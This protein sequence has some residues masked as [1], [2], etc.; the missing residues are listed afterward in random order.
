MAAGGE[1]E[2]AGPSRPQ[3]ARMPARHFRRLIARVLVSKKNMITILLLGGST[4]HFFREHIALALR[5][6]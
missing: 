2:A 6:R 4:M 1:E 3:D 5:Q